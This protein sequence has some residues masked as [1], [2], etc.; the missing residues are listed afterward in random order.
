MPP[1]TH[2]LSEVF[3]FPVDNFSAEAQR[4]RSK[5]LCPFNNKVPNCTKDKANDPL[6]TCS[7][8]ADNGLAITCPIRFRQDWIIAD[9]GADFFFPKDAKWT[10]LTEVKLKDKSDRSAGN[11][12]LVLVSY[13]DRGK[14][15]DFGALEIQAVYISG[16]IRK[17]FEYYMQ[18]VKSR[19]N[20][21]WK[22]QDYWPRPDYLSSSRKRLAAQLIFKSGILYAWKKKTAVALDAG[23]FATLPH[24]TEVS[25][26]KA[27]IAW[28]VYDLELRK[29]DNRYILKKIQTVYTEFGS[30][31]D[32]IT[33]SE[34]GNVKDFIGVLQEKLDEK[35]SNETPPDTQT[36]DELL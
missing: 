25:R 17:P 15:L 19:A 26:E 18:D 11:I 3:G 12:D 22:G 8:S 4:H 14:V 27:D 13:D 10:S 35:L 21:S 6:G 1:K 9:H 2:P 7:I 34:P 20:M 16:N 31:L 5:K 29:P 33:R 24:L 23:F 30:S 28:L 36:I 32:Q